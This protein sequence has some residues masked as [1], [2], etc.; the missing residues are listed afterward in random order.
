MA[1]KIKVTLTKSPI[2][3]PQDHKIT[4]RTLGLKKI[5]QAVVHDDTPQIRGMLYQVRHLVQAE[6]VKKGK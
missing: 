1:K 5:R 6:E 4:V 3:Y 2:G